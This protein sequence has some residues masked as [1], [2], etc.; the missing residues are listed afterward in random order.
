MN[1]IHALLFPLMKTLKIYLVGEYNYLNIKN[2]TK[3]VMRRST[4]EGEDAIGTAKGKD[5]HLIL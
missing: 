4:V 1:K 2:I 5:I 3:T